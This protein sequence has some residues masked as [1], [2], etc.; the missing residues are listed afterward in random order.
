MGSTSGKRATSFTKTKKITLIKGPLL[1]KGEVLHVEEEICL[2]DYH[3][4]LPIY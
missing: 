4:N 1:I 3:I 2:K